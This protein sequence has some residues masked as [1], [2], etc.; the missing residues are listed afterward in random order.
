MVPLGGQSTRNCV[1]H[2]PSGQMGVRRLQA[3]S[4]YCLKK[5]CPATGAR[6]LTNCKVRFMANRGRAPDIDVHNAN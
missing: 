4:E 2:W 6:V 5:E 3:R 1:P